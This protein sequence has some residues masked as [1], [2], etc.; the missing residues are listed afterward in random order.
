MLPQPENDGAARLDML[1][2]GS[3]SV[4]MSAGSNGAFSEKVKVSS[5]AL[6]VTGVPMVNSLERNDV[7]LIALDE[8]MGVVGRSAALAKENATVRDTKFASCGNELVVKPVAMIVHCVSL[9]NE[10]SAEMTN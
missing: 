2:S 4:I 5:V 9:D 6:R 10:T 1:N 8:T 3:T 7:A